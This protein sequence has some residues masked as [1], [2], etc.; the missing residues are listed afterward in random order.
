MRD[1]QIIAKECLKELDAIGIQYGNIKEFV[2]NT[3]AKSRWGQCK[4]VPGGFSINISEDLLREENSIIGLKNTIIHEIL[5]TVPGC[6]NHGDA[7]KRMAARVNDVYDYNVKRC[8]SA[9]E[10]GV[11]T[12]I[13]R[14]KKTVKHQVQCKK[15]GYLMN[16]A[17]SSKVTNHPELYRCGVCGGRL[18]TLF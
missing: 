17:R 5:H 14:I 7:W 8:S 12:E 4:V 2:V 9:D 13:R 15:C 6:F 18:V 3:R 10:K 16:Y 1:L 11:V